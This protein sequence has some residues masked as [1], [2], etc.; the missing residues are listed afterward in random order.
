MA[1]AKVCREAGARVTTNVLVRD[2]DL[3]VPHPALDGRRLE[4]VAEGLRGGGGVQLALDTSLVSPVRAD[5][6]ARPGAAQRDGVALVSAWRLK[7]RTYPELVGRGARPDWSCS[8]AK[9]AAVGLRR[10]VQFLAPVGRSESQ[11]R[12]THP[13]AESEVCLAGQL[14]CD[15]VLRCRRG[16]RLLVAEPSWSGRCRW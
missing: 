1:A 3:G 4:V 6:T 10:N 11:T 15:L 16:V 8:R 5:G 9:S 2:L 14:G 12:T 13:P 7:E